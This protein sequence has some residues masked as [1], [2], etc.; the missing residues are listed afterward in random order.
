MILSAQLLG[1]LRAYWKL[2]RRCG[3]QFPGRDPD[4]PLTV[5]VLHV[6][7]RSAV[8]AA[9]LSKRVT[10]HTLLHSFVTHLLENGTD[11]RIIQLLLGHNKQSSTTRSAQVSSGLIGMTSSPLDRLGLEVVPP[12]GSMAMPTGPEMAD[13][14]R[15]DG[16][17]YRR[18]HDGHIGRVER[19]VMSVI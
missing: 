8:A 2:A 10:V 16:E 18:A 7:S 17:A 13:V 12:A 14:F 3:W 4:Q 15:R 1:I 19:R 9:G 5:K 11:I 6:A